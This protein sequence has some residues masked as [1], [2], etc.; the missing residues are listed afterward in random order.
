[1]RLSTFLTIM[2]GTVFIPT[3]GTLRRMDP[4]EASEACQ[5]TKKFFEELDPDSKSVLTSLGTAEEKALLESS[6][7]A[8]QERHIYFEIWKREI[9]KRRCIW[10]W[11]ERPESKAM[12]DI[13]AN[14][15]V[16]VCTTIARLRRAIKAYTVDSGIIARIRYSDKPETEN[17]PELLL[18]PYLFKKSSYSHEHEVRV[19]FPSEPHEN[20]PGHKLQISGHELVE[21]VRI[22]P[23]IPADEAKE[24][25]KFLRQ[26]SVTEL[27]SDYEKEMSVFPSEVYR[28]R[29]PFDPRIDAPFPRAHGIANFGFHRMPHVLSDDIRRALRPRPEWTSKPA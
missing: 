11:H 13:Y 5:N 27:R 6:L 20:Y 17:D 26:L 7:E 23:D 14:A 8:W 3:I 15:G 4:T 28:V 16:A 25:A 19:V 21:E 12:W 29:R 10:C 1:M 18:R 24:L 9:G 22:S 2:S